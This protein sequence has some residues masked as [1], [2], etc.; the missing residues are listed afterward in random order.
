MR[1]R[2]GRHVVSGI[3]DSIL[4]FSL[5][6]FFWSLCACTPGFDAATYQKQ[7]EEKTG[8]HTES[9][10][11]NGGLLTKTHRGYPVLARIQMGEVYGRFA[12]RVAAGE[13]GRQLGRIGQ[14]ATGS[15]EHVGTVVGSPFDRALSAVIG[16]PISFFVVLKHGKKNPPALD[17]VSSTSTIKPTRQLGK[18]GGLGLVI[19]ETA[20]SND[21][22]L[23]KHIEE[24]KSLHDR[25]T[26][27]RSYYLMLDENTVSFFFAASENEWSAMIRAYPTY[28]DFINAVMDSLADIAE[29]I[30]K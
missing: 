27:F 11:A 14:F 29:L 6:V 2:L 26:S 15:Y 22:I 28:E 20:Y 21:Q 23:W 30:G 7:F 12:A 3:P 5:T 10:D 18:V 25:L 1:L 4:H 8:L 17:I 24:N 9:S 13:I 16:Q 19:G